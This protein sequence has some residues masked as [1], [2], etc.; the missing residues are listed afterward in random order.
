MRNKFLGTGE[1]GFHP[2]RKIRVVLSGLKYAVRYDFSVTYKLM[3]SAVVLSI[4]FFFRK[5]IDFL[6]LAAATA[7]MLQAELFNSAIEAVCDFITTEKSRRV[8]VIKD[9]SAAAAGICILLWGII[10][11]IETYQVLRLFSILH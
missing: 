8:K 5:W 6:L 2:L 3:L 9:I 11:A 1:T 7:M 10:L 4:F